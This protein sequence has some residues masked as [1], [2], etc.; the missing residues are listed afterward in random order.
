MLT[1]LTSSNDDPGQS[2]PIGI[3]F[4]CW[5]YGLEGW[6]D[7]VHCCDDLVFF[8]GHGVSQRVDGRAR[9]HDILFPAHG[10]LVLG[11]PL[12]VERFEDHATHVAEAI[13]SCRSIHLEGSRCHSH[14]F[15]EAYD[16]LTLLFC[17]SAQAYAH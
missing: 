9:P 14:G 12:I 6:T 5:G 15:G 10:R 16:F 11:P 7:L 17:C 3:L 8:G 1:R 13:G 4:F 2:H